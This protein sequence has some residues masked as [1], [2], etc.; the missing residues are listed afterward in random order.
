L[1][2]IISFIAFYACNGLLKV[3]FNFYTALLLL[4]ISGLTFPLLV[5]VLY[6]YVFTNLPNKKVIVIGREE[7]WGD[8]LE[9]INKQSLRTFEIL[10]YTEVNTPDLLRE[11]VSDFDKVNYIIT[12]NSKDLLEL[13]GSRYNGVRVLSIHILAENYLKKIPTIVL[14]SFSDYY[15]LSLANP[16]RS[17]IAILTDF[18]ISVFLL[19]IS[20]PI[21]IISAIIIL[22]VDGGPIFFLQ[23]RHGLFGKKFKIFKLR[24]MDLHKDGIVRTTKSGHL[25][26]KLRINEIPQLMNIIKGDMSLIGPRPDV[27]STYEFCISRIPMYNYRTFVLPGITGNAQ[28]NYKYIDHLDEEAFTERLAYDLHYLKNQTAFYYIS[29][30]LKTFESLFRVKGK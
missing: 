29:I 20:S 22:L 16:I 26:R 18:F 9:D 4:S 23:E 25:L 11:T 7:D 24:T 6:N 3:P 28:L 17:K 27:P 14:N 21:L 8:L 12:T 5:Y 15:K 2:N 1:A 19:I 10:A 30:F 13:K